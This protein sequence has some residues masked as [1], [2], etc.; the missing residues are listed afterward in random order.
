[1]FHEMKI[2]VKKQIVET[3]KKTWCPTLIC[4]TIYFTQKHIGSDNLSN[5][6]CMP[7]N[8]YAIG[9][10]FGENNYKIFISIIF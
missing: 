5:T 8:Y 3:D 7:K 6:N 4:L 2:I 10:N 9:Q 1:M